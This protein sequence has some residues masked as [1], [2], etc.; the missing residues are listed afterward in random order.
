MSNFNNS[1]YQKNF[2]ECHKQFVYKK[3]HEQGGQEDTF[4]GLVNVNDSF[5][6]SNS[7]ITLTIADSF[8]DNVIVKIKNVIIAI[9]VALGVQIPAELQD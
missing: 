8:D 9:L 4:Y 6:I 2:S 7:T 3:K 1:P 5:N